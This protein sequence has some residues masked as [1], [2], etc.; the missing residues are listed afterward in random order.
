[1][2]LL[3]SGKVVVLQPRLE[4]PRINN[5]IASVYGDHAITK[6]PRAV[7]TMM[8]MSLLRRIFLSVIL[9]FGH[10]NVLLQLY[11]LYGSSLLFMALYALYKPI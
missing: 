5:R 3:E 4:A 11:F 9:I 7:I 10:K 6:A 1:M 2:N 8:F